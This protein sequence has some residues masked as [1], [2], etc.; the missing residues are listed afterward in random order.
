MPTLLIGWELGGG[1][2]HIH[3]LNP[4]IAGYLERNWKVVAALRLRH[5]AEAYFSTIFPEALADSRLVVVQAPI[6]LHRRRPVQAASLAHLFAQ[7]GFAEADLLRPVVSAW[8]RLLV[9]H[10]PDAV[11][12]DTAPSLNLAAA[13]RSPII[14]IGNGWTIPPDT[15]RATPFQTGAL[16]QSAADRASAA[17]LETASRVING[18]HP[19]DRFSDLLRGQSNMVC[20]FGAFDPYVEQRDEPYFW[21][22]EIPSET[23][24]TASRD[25]GFIYLPRDHPALPAMLDALAV[26][27][28]QFDGYFGGY[29]P[30]VPN[31]TAA[32][33][34]LDLAR[35]LPAAMVAVHHGGL[36][37]AIECWINRVPQL[38]C[39]LDTEKWIIGRGIEAGHAGHIASP[40]AQPNDLRAMIERVMRVPVAPPDHA[41]MAT[42]NPEESLKML[43]RHTE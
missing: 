8:E 42:F 21:P 37:T 4:I 1:G 19:F 33:N 17:V 43:F 40:A 13:G 38:V 32:A 22:F 10:R 41:R 24:R 28:C 27:T 30:S 35:I 18:R 11:L 29:C 39:P 2:G 7:I 15:E 31:L 34:P 16:S 5:A 14:V 36:G 12:S 20:T 25:T 26:G 23:L 9:V 3:R 6:F